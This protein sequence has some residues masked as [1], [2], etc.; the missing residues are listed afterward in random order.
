MCRLSTLTN[1]GMQSAPSSKGPA[2]R[3]AISRATLRVGLELELFLN[4]CG[5]PGAVRNGLPMLVAVVF[6]ARIGGIA[7][8]ALSRAEIIGAASA[9]TIWVTW[10]SGT[11]CRAPIITASSAVAVLFEP[12]E[13]FQFLTAARPFGWIPFLTLI[14]GSVWIAVPSLMAKFSLYGTFVWSLARLGLRWTFATSPTAVFVFLIHY[15][16]SYLPGRSAEITDA[17][18]VLMA[19]GLMKIVDGTRRGLGPFLG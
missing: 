4:R 12:L 5:V 13:P 1:T 15:L 9:A 3:L 18:L 2:L 6:C 19:G 14:D 17:L 16:Q 7:D 8:I 11:K 10:L